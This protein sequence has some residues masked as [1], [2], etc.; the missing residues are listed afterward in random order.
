LFADN[1]AQCTILTW[2]LSA[3]ATELQP[4]AAP[5]RAPRRYRQ[6]RLA[7]T[8]FRRTPGTFS[9]VKARYRFG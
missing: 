9:A 7:V 8:W 5:L 4:F 3:E 1:T 6:N 2:T